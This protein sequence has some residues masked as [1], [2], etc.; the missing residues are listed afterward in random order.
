MLKAFCGCGV[1]AG[2]PYFSFKMTV[3]MAA[4]FRGLPLGAI[5][6]T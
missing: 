1:W 6:I 2:A 5:S 4:S 3:F